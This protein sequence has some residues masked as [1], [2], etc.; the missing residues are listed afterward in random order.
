M[1]PKFAEWVKNS[2]KFQK[3]HSLLKSTHDRDGQTKMFIRA[4]YSSCLHLH[5]CVG[6][7]ERSRINLIFVFNNNFKH[8][9]H[10][11]YYWRSIND[12]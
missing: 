8:V 11:D 5:R 1:F 6:A 4:F 3:K 7:S 10:L 2:S 9:Q 12:L